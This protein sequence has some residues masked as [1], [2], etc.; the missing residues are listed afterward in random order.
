[1]RSGP[2]G[3]DTRRFIL[4]TRV[5]V[6]Q[7][8]KV[9]PPRPHATYQRRPDDLLVTTYDVTRIPYLG[10]TLW[11]YIDTPTWTRQLLLVFPLFF[12]FLKLPDCSLW[13]SRNQRIYQFEPIKTV[14]GRLPIHGQVPLRPV[15]LRFIATLGQLSTRATSHKENCPIL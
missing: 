9:L 8:N 15:S 10:E 13:V 7:V 3:G 4:C 1:M 2:W 11:G 5:V 14:A 12:S 6:G